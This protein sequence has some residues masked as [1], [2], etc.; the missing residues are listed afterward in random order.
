LT[1][2][3]RFSVSEF[4]TLT[5][6]REDLAA[7]STGGATGIGIAEVKL[8]PGEDAASLRELR[9]SGLS[10]VVCLPELLSI[11]PNELSTEPRDTEARVEAL[12]RSIRRLAR[13]EPE[14]VL[15][16]TGAAGERD[17][18]EVRRLVV[19]GV[20]ELG[21]V[22]REA[23]VRVALEPIHRSAEREFTIVT[24]LPG[25]EELLAQAGDDSIGIIFDTW[26]LWDTP[27]VLEHIRRLAP[28]IPAV[29]VNDW[30][31]QTRNWDDRALPGDGV[32]DLPA[33]LGALDAAGFDGFY[34]LEIFSSE[35]YPDSLY[36]IEPAELVRRGRAGFERAWEARSRY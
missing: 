8:P 36:A 22:G 14:V 17:A 30:R 12:A 25:A 27:D 11:L 32:I 24:D 23:G 3:P 15:F 21:S 7:F 28:R 2:V 33:L 1:G 34:E 16:L 35:T 6:Y 18:A 5:G 19:E 20:R 10:A 29:H 9:A 13:F 4:S 26:H 31:A